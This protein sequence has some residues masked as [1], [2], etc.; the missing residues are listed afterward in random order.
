MAKVEGVTAVINLFRRAEAR[1]GEANVSVLVGYTAAYA[2][3]VHEKIE[4][5]LAGQPRKPPGKGLYWDPQG[6]AQAKF[7]EGPARELNSSGVLGQ[8]V[9][10]VYGKTRSVL[11]ALLVAGGRLL[12]ESQLRVPVDTGNL[13]ASGFL[14]KE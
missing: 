11:Q 9:R 4:M 10:E 8:I 5:K 1:A 3:A 12:R 7:L 2:L 6:R 14:R 13:K